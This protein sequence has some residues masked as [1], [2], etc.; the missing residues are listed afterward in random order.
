[1]TLI[2][3]YY[4]CI[5]IGE[6]S[7]NN[8]ISLNINLFTVNIHAIT[9]ER[10]SYEYDINSMFFFVFCFLFLIKDLISFLKK[11]I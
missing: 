11:K 9:I 6:K 1:M 10:S 2:Q 7:E 3:I 4:S 8:Q 5:F